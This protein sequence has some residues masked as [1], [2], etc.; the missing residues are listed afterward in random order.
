MKEQIAFNDRYIQ[1]TVGYLRIKNK[2]SL[3]KRWIVAPNH[4]TARFTLSNRLKSGWTGMGLEPPLVNL[5][6]N[7]Q[8]GS[9]HIGIIAFI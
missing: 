2:S 3:G 5:G 6:L 9:V 1:V 7:Q 8:K 4:D